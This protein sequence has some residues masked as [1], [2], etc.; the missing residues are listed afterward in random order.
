MGIP[1]V[2]SNSGV[3]A[4]VTEVVTVEQQQER[5]QSKMEPQTQL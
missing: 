5:W 3:T 4:G 1:L 2:I